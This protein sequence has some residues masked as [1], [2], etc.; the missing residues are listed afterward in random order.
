VSDFAGCPGM[1]R[2]DSLSP[3]KSVSRLVSWVVFPWLVTSLWFSKVVFV[4]V[5]MGCPP[6]CVGSLSLEKSF[7]CWVSWVV[8]S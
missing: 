1:I 7:S 4:S 5:F 6:I 3:K 8:L 2:I